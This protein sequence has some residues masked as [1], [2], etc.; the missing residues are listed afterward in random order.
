MK[1]NP[2]ATLVPNERNSR[3]CHSQ[4]CNS[5][6]IRILHALFHIWWCIQN[7][8]AYINGLTQNICK[9]KIEIYFL[10]GYSFFFQWKILRKKAS[11]TLLYV[12]VN[13]ILYWPFICRCRVLYHT[14]NMINN[15]RNRIYHTKTKIFTSYPNF[16]SL[17]Y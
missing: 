13:G 7:S 10:S 12:Y 8:V 15:I 11:L 16:F 2:C 5:T 4:Y 17:K 14:R 6:G 1:L 9:K 3:F